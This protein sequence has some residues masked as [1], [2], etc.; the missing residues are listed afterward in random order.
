LQTIKDIFVL[1]LIILAIPF[2]WQ[3]VVLLF[4]LAIAAYSVLLVLA[5]PA[6][7]I[8]GIILLIGAIHGYFSR[9]D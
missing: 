4:S 8:S 3:V 2:L 7:I 6:L 5:I 9:S 1:A